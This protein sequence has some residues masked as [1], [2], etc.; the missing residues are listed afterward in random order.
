MADELLSQEEINALLSG[1][2]KGEVELGEGALTDVEVIPYDL[3]SK[4]V[5]L[6]DQFGALEEVFVKFT[7]RLEK[8][9][10]K[11]IKKPVEVEF[12]SSEII[13]YEDYINSFPTPT[14]FNIFSMDPLVGGAMVVVAPNLLFSLIDCMFGGSGKPL[15][16]DREF[17]LIDKR[18]MERVVGDILEALEESWE[19]IQPIRPRLKHTETRPEFVHLVTPDD[20]IIT[21]SFEINGAEFKGQ[22]C[23][24]LSYLML[25]PIKEKLSA[26]YLSKKDA[27]QS[28]RLKLQQ[29]LKET[30]VMVIAELGRTECAI[31]DLLELKVNDVLKLDTGPEDFIRVNIENVEKFNGHPGILKGN[32]AVQI[33]TTE[34]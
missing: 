19:S 33:T 5:T 22:F 30:N 23:L 25:E 24:C 27:D 28:W 10:S 32:R 6:N 11:A 12:V 31:R 9:I 15:T 3:T 20:F 14:G 13:K 26:E 21:N 18:M 7:N 2:A 17:S 34:S 16:M 1:M 29:L 8:T 4:S